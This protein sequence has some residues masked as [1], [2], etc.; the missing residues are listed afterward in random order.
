L[1][2]DDELREKMGENASEKIKKFNLTKIGQ[3]FE[4]VL[5]SSS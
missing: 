5:L 2:K 3:K 1:I 4:A